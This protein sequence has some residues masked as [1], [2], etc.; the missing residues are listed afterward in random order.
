M[1]QLGLA[2][3]SYYLVLATIDL[4]HP[5]KEIEREGREGS[6]TTSHDHDD[7]DDGSV[8]IMMLA[9]LLLLLLLV[10]IPS[11]LQYPVFLSLTNS[12]DDNESRR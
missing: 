6:T 7:C 9:L 5:T 2:F 12:I 1:K 8:V 11:Y 4:F 10:A 3:Q